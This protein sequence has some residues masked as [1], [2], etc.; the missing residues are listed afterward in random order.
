MV[1]SFASARSV[2]DV[3]D[4]K[5]DTVSRAV[6]ISWSVEV[7][8]FSKDDVS[9]TLPY[10][11]FP[12]G[13]KATLCRAQTQGVLPLFG[14]GKKY[15]LGESITRGEAL[16]V[17]STFLKKTEDADVSAFSDVTSDADTLA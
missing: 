14:D 10:A 6:F 12:R 11:R 1:P 15:T 13:L 16:L 4:S 9:C 5:A 3:V 7:L 17:L 2:S 8:G